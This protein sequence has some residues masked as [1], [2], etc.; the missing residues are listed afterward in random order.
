MLI[1]KVMFATVAIFLLLNGNVSVA[2][3]LINLKIT[4]RPLR[5]VLIQKQSVASLFADLALS[6]DIPIGVEVAQNDEDVDNY[7]LDF[8]HGTVRQLLD[9][10]CSEHN[11]YTWELQEGVVNV[12]PKPKYRDKALEKTIERKDRQIQ[13]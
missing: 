7:V 1:N 11:L 5:N 3:E 8:E 12:F 10:F 2:Q 4:E 6:C 13:D 9:Q